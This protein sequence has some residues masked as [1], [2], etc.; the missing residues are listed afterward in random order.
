MVRF[1]I[2]VVYTLCFSV[3]NHRV[4]KEKAQSS[5]RNIRSKTKWLPLS[6]RIHLIF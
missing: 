3:K 1:P 6:T 2:L 4:R 5:Q